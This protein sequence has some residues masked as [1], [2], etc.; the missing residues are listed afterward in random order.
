MIFILNESS[1][2]QQQKKSQFVKALELI[3]SIIL[4][5]KKQST[6]I[7][8]SDLVGLMVVSVKSM[9]KANFIKK[10]PQRRCFLVNFDRTEW[11][12][13]FSQNTFGWLLLFR[14]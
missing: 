6:K 7:V 14:K 10:R 8:L 12:N 1:S 9:K 4:K 11:M 5:K 13:L 3:H 2:F